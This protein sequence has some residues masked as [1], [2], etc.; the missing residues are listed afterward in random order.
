M[1]GLAHNKACMYTGQL[2]LEKPQYYDP[3]PSG[4]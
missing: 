4:I 2:L 1:V 3:A